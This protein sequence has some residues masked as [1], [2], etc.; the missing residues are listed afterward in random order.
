[1]IENTKGDMP[2]MRTRARIINQLGQQLIKSESIALLE[3]VKNSYD[4]DATKCTIDMYSPDLPEKG[5]IVVKDNGEGMD[6][7]TL[8]TAWLEIGTSYKEDLLSNT[9]TARSPKYKRRR[10]GEK[11]IGRFGVHRLGTLIEIVSRKKASKE[12]ILKIDW[13]TI[14]KSKYV[15]EI[16]I[17]ISQREPILFKQGS[18]T[19]ITIRDLLVPWSRRM[20]RDCAR[21][22]TALNSP[23]DQEESFRAAFNLHELDWLEGI[24]KF[25]DIEEYK[26]F[27]F[28]VTIR[29]ND[30]TDFKYA[31]TPWKTMKKLASRVVTIKDKEIS[32]LT[33]MVYGDEDRKEKDINLDNYKIGTIVFKGIIFDRDARVLNL[34]VQDKKGLKEYLDQNGGVRVFRDNIRVL[35]YGEPGNDWLDLSGRRINIPTRR[36]S[37]NIIIAAIYFDRSQSNDLIEKANREG[38]LENDAFLEV[39]RAI[40]FVIDR[41]EAVR[42]R[43]KG[44]LRLHYGAQKVSEP[45]RGTITELKAVVIK[46]IANKSELL[47]ITQYLDRIES[48]Y[49]SIVDTLMRSAGAGLNLVIVIHQIEKVIKEIRGML[50]HH[51]SPDLI[52]ERVKSLA[53][54]VEGYSILIKR[55]DKKVRNLKGLVEQGV[56]NTS[57]RFEAHNIKLDAAFRNKSRNLDAVLST[58]HA[59]NALMNVIDNSIWWLGYSRPKEPTIYID[60]SG[61]LEGYVSIVIADNGPGFTLPTSEIIKPWVTNKPGGS[62][63]GLHLT[64][65]IM[66]SLGGALLFPDPGDYSVPKKYWKGAITVLAFRKG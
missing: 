4:A 60:I 3:L 28:D 16:P 42:M 43:D 5:K 44:L 64:D 15:E 52:E 55:S 27:S 31:F 48:E 10:L 22:I 9:A 1:M 53:G 20:T 62:G 36:I 49:D 21:A 2:K 6:Y 12:C 41:I 35:D 34:G 45:V 50:Q 58:N 56:F 26:L 54:L 13:S 51:A 24:V 59:L 11:G 63:I 14:K 17:E 61:E 33:R 18:G 66:Q 25:E 38:F 47:K 32:K 57:F 37:N 40:R 29:G 30:I 65:Q 23:F 8:S 39:V 19:C 46:S 7:E